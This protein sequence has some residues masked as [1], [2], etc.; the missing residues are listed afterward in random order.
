[1]GPDEIL[2]AMESF[3]HIKPLPV[4]C[5]PVVLCSCRH[6][7]QNYVCIESAVVSLLHNTELEVPGIALLKQ[8]K[9]REQSELA[10]P[11]NSNKLK[12]Q[13]TASY[14]IIVVDSNHKFV[15][16]ILI[17]LTGMGMTSRL[18]FGLA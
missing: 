8:M 10:N 9:E 7:F 5:S 11:F 12:L 16:Q 2:D 3:D 18:A 1:M 17:P 4:K 15:Q 6:C 14:R 13:G